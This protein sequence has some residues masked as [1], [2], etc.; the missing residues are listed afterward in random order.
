MRTPTDKPRV[1]RMVAYVQ[2]NFWAGEKFS[3]LDQAQHAAR[4]WC[5]RVGE[6]RHGTTGTRPL[7]CFT[8][9]EAPVLKPVP[10]PYDVPIFTH[11]KVHRDFHAS[12]GRALYSLPEQWIGQRVQ[13]RADSTQVR[14]TSGGRLIKTH[15]RMPAGGR[16]TDPADYP[17]HKS[18]YALRD[19]TKLIA[20][21]ERHGPHI[22]T[23]AARILDDRLPWTRMR[24]AYT[25]L[26]L[27]KTYVDDA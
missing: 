26:G 6:R 22:G 27:V 13:V 23:Y 18:D 2:N 21:A 4:A 12:V 19:V 1:E 16:S 14:F 5:T 9:D 24:A 17:D 10:A 20:A 7:D 15:P 3:S 8:R 25:L 11:A